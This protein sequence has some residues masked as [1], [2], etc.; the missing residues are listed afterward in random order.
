MRS[1]FPG[2]SKPQVKVLGEYSLGMVLA[3]RCGLSCAAFALARWVGQTF[4]AVRERLRDWYCGAADKSGSGRGRKRRELGV[5]GC[6]AA[7]LAWVLRGWA[8]DQLAVALDATTLGTRFVVLA[9]SVVYRAC[10]IP[11]AWVVLP[12]TAKGAWKPHWLATPTE[13]QAPAGSQRLPQ[14]PPD[15]PSRPACQPATTLGRFLPDPW[16]QR[17]PAPPLQAAP[18]RPP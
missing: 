12:A 1:V 13:A 7:L 18:E 5:A 17:T 10:A 16:P 4:D 11:V 6:F 8:G 2:L 14:G 9:I 15:R 3:G